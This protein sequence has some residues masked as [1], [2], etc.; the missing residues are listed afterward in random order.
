ML[1][2]THFLLS[3]LH[4]LQLE[5]PFRVSPSYALPQRPLLAAPVVAVL[6][7]VVLLVG[8]LV[9][10]TGEIT[11]GKRSVEHQVAGILETQQSGY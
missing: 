9:V 5:Q 7:M 2:W 10:A 1:S 3:E 11:S 8:A 4:L 6:V